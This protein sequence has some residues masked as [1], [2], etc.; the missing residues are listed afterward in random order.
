MNIGASWE[1]SIS[2]GA[3]LGKIGPA[4]HPPEGVEQFLRVLPVEPPLALFQEPVERVPGHPVELPQVPLGLAPEVL[5]AVNV[6]AAGTGQLLL[7]V[8]PHV[9]VPLD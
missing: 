2:L 9:P 1:R 6:P 5:D 8:D 3:G 7:V 4:E